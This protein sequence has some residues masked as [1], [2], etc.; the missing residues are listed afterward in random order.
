MAAG[1]RAKGA[2]LLEEPRILLLQQHKCNTQVSPH[3]SDTTRERF[4]AKVLELIL[5]KERKE[6]EQTVDDKMEDLRN[7]YRDEMNNQVSLAEK[8]KEKMQALEKSLQ[9]SLRSKRKDFDELKVLCDDSVSKVTD[10]ER[11]L[12]NQTNEVLRL[13]AEL[14]SYE[15]E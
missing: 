3:I 12:E 11:R 5:I 9:E 4:K 14:E 2:T 10:L 7:M 8:E 13:T 6:H 15:Y 1:R